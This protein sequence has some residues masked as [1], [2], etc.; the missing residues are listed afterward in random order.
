MKHLCGSQLMPWHLPVPTSLLRPLWS[1][2]PLVA[3][4]V[5]RVRVTTHIVLPSVASSTGPYNINT[6]RAA[7]REMA[8]LEIQNNCKFDELS[9]C[10][11]FWNELQLHAPSLMGSHNV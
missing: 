2:G 3:L 7:T 9:Q 10:F 6:N 11:S 8:V 5:V 1:A 4:A